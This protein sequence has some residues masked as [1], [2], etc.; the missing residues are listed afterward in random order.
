MCE[1]RP[2][3]SSS[4]AALGWMWILSSVSVASIMRREGWI[5]RL[6]LYLRSY[7]AD[8][9]WYALT[10]ERFRTSMPDETQ[11]QSSSPFTVENRNHETPL[12]SPRRA[13]VTLYDGLAYFL[14]M[15]SPVPTRITKPLS[16]ARA[17]IQDT[18]EGTAI[19]SNVV[20]STLETAV[21]F[22]NM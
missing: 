9:R 8:V 18:G 5:S 14:I 13:F 20:S 11:K 15:P 19:I 12:E 7:C 3:F 10:C 22:P 21:I 4:S 16:T 6:K 2:S 1:I 17:S